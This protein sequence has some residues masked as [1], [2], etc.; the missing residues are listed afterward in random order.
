MPERPGFARALG[1]IPSGLF[2]VTAGTGADATGF[3]ASF[4]QQVGF[5]PPMITTAIR[6][7]RPAEDA[8]RANGG[9]CVAILDEV[10]R[11]LMNHFARGFE[12]GEWAFTGVA[13]DTTESGIP[14]PTE[15]LA[16]LECR[17]V[18]E[19]VWSDHVL[20]CG[21]VIGGWHRGIGQPLIHVRKSGLGY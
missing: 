17:V 8:V 21:E 4:V 16:L 14:Y 20:F 12:R 18:G 1:A 19:V 7:G 10:S 15:A 13:I 11:N 2:I 6:R 9:L 3:L 5:A